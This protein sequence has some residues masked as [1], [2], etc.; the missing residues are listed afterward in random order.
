[1]GGDRTGRVAYLCH[2][3]PKHTE[4]FVYREVERLLEFGADVVVYAM[5][6]PGNPEAVPGAIEKINTTT[7]LPPD[8]GVK[9][10]MAQ[11]LCLLTSP[12]R[13]LTLLLQ[14]LFVDEKRAVIP[15]EVRFGMFLRGALAARLLKKDDRISILHCPATGDELA[16]AHV[17]SALSGIPLSFTLHAP[18]AL[19]K[20]SPLLA[21]HARH[22]SLIVSI[23]EYARR[24]IIE[25]AGREI[26]DKVKVIRCGVDLPD[27]T[28]NAGDGE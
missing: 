5:K 26:A 10:W 6:P 4:T 14:F 7:Y 25:L 28:T 19:F 15:L 22:A 8:F 1:M 20:G 21:G 27:K 3:Y 9:F 23:S 24:R 2:E 17:A 11:C 16:A 13:Y 12:I 18:L